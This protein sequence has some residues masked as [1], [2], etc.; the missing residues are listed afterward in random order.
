[1]NRVQTVVSV[2]LTTLCLASICMAQDIVI[3]QNP[4]C[5]TDDGS[6]VACGGNGTTAENW[7]AR[8]FYIDQSVTVNSIHWG[9]AN[10]TSVSANIFFSVAS[11]P[12]NPEGLTLI[13]V[14][15]AVQ[16][17]DAGPFYDT[18][19][20][21]PFDLD[22]GSYLVV[23][24]QIPDTGTDAG[25]WPANTPTASATTYLKAS[26]CGIEAYTDVAGIGFPD[27][28]MIMCLNGTAADFDPCTL[29]LPTTCT[30]DV[31]GDMVVAVGDLLTII[32][33]W[34]ECGDSSYRPIGD[35]AP[36]PD[37]DCCVNVS[38]LL[39]VIAAWGSDC[40]PR[41]AC[42]S[43]SG[44]CTD[45]MTIDDCLASDG[46]YLG[47]DTTCA[48]GLCLSGAC[49][50]DAQTCIDGV[51]PWYCAEYQGSFRGD[52][53]M[54]ADISCDGSCNATGCQPADLGGHGADGIIGATSDTNPDAGYVVADT[55]NPTENGVVSQACW[56]GMYID[57]GGPSDC[58]I[59][60]PGTG[61]SFT[62]SYYLDDAGSTIPGTLYA[63]PFEVSAGVSATGDMIPSGIGDI[64][65]YEYSASHAPVKVQ[66][67]E[68]YWISISNQ[69]T[70]TCFWLWETAPAGDNRSAQDNG[71]WGE[72]DYDLAFCV[73]ID[74]DPEACGVFTGP[75]CLPGF[76]CEIMTEA[77]CAI[78]EG[79]YKGNNLSCAD[80][81]DCQPI[82]GACCFSLNTCIGNTTDQDCIAFDG[83]FMG[84]G[85][86]CEDVNC[87]YDQIGPLDGTL[88]VEAET[89]ACQIF[90]E[91]NEA[92][93]IATLD[94]FMFDDQVTVTSIETV[95][96]GWNG[97]NGLDAVT[98]YT[99][100]IYSSVDAAGADLV[101]D[102]YS[103]DIVEPTF[104]EWNG[105]GTLVELDVIITLPA[106]EYYFAI[107]PWN[108]YGENGQTGIKG[109]T[110]GD[111]SFYQANPNGGFGFGAW[112]QGIGNAAYRVNTQ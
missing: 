63:G 75:C 38:D 28:Q 87:G 60:G 61:D 89:T 15:T 40:L 99:I 85:S 37:G 4:D 23:E 82:P 9:A 57:F 107:I 41:G 59:S 10:V 101:G 78:A 80:I 64:V 34:G 54:C 71:G 74:I 3:T 6:M 33:N 90:E 106:G 25:I 14:G 111:G 7:F 95:I 22:P 30:E 35:I 103:V 62:I 36:M 98:N 112:Q 44:M 5:E 110:L 84:E 11:G 69:T 19:V 77:D 16:A 105:A 46:E 73:D 66:A 68:C 92:Y 43:Q 42:C 58:G 93:N 24:F 102:V 47:D 65:Q 97:Y 94:N 2:L 45:A 109:S 86:I 100:S 39:A 67:G 48:D 26:E 52:G 18:P 104:P 79:V 17:I 108:N 12:G 91:A 88:I 50:I 81:N 53:T 31:D 70:G 32:G 1:M 83:I 76:V 56:W 72:S 29:P 20:D 96:D 55:F 8:N 27:S 21:V 13:P 51:S 49:C